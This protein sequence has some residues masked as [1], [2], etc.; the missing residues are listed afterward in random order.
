MLMSRI[1]QKEGGYQYMK[2]IIF[3]SFITVVTSTYAYSNLCATAGVVI[4]LN[5]FLLQISLSLNT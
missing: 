1:Q 2:R 3:H 4:L 5:I